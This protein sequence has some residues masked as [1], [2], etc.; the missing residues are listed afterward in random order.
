M[1]KPTNYPLRYRRGSAKLPSVLLRVTR[2]LLSGL[3]IATGLWLTGCSSV[4]REPQIEVWDD[5]KRQGK[6]KPQTRKLV[7]RRP[8]HEPPS[9]GR[10]R[11][12]RLP[13]RR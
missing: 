13:Q 11:R 2:A 8:S 5:M 3:L 7:L 12:A 4:S 9:T 6:Y 1:L 10:Y